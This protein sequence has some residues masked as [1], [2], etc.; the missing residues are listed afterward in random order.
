MLLLEVAYTLFK[1]A[2]VSFQKLMRLLVGS[3]YLC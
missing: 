2:K 1:L 3:L